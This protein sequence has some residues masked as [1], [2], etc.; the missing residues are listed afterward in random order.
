M[1]TTL[2][3]TKIRTLQII[4]FLFFLGMIFINFLANYLPINGKNTGQVSDQYPNL[5]VPAPIT[6]SIWSVIYLLLF[7]FCIYQMTSLLKTKF[8]TYVGQLFTN[9]NT[10]FILTCILNMCW[11]VAWHYDLIVVSVILMLL[12]LNRL[13]YIDSQIRLLSPYLTGTQNFVIKAPFGLYL[14]WICIATIANITALLVNFGWRGVGMTEESWASTLVLIGSI[15]GVLAIFKFNNFY[16]GLAIIWALSGIIIERT[17]AI[18]YYQ[19]IVLSAWA[20]IIILVISVLI[21]L[22]R[23]G[24]RKKQPLINDRL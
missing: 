19:Y 5:F 2:N 4:S 6:F 9:I 16:I 1:E 23:G 13:I 10:G 24:L 14:G 21:E 11:I 17:N 8:D 20:G 3:T 18:T 12:L 7:I 22:F 15:I